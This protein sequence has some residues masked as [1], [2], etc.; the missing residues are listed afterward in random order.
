MQFFTCA[1]S[2]WAWTKNRTRIRDRN[3]PSKHGYVRVGVLCPSWPIGRCC[4]RNSSSIGRCGVVWCAGLWT[5][6]MHLVGILSFIVCWFCFAAFLA[7]LG[8]W[9]S[10]VCRT[11]RQ[12][13][14]VAFLT[15]SVIL[16]CA[17]VCSFNLAEK[18]IP[19]YEAIGLF[20]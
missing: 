4:G 11:T 20:P 12:A 10:V 6:S 2:L 18:Y 5:G 7:S 19:I 1:A 14:A 3:S 8:I 16:G 17:A 9:F 15:F 13:T